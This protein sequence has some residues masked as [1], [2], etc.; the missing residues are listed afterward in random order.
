[1]RPLLV[2]IML[3]ACATASPPTAPAPAPPTAPAPARRSTPQLTLVY[4]AELLEQRQFARF[5]DE[6]MWP[7]ELVQMKTNGK[8]A[9]ILGTLEQGYGQTLARIL[10]NAELSMP[11]QRKDGGVD[12]PQGVGQGAITLAPLDGR[13]YLT[14]RPEE[15]SLFRNIKELHVRIP[16]DLS[17]AERGRRFDEPLTALLLEKGLGSVISGGTL[18]ENGKFQFV[19]LDVSVNDLAI[20]LPLVRQKLRELKAPRG[21]VIEEIETRTVHPVW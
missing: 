17:P 21:T 13:W 4:G 6:L 16:E 11:R 10:R 8:R 3:V 9:E 2:L 19:G 15:S 12:Y 20:G 18:R 14:R 1:M 5:I 7:G